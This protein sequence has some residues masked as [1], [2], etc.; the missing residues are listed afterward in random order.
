M[1]P[2]LYEARRTVLTYPFFVWERRFFLRFSLPFTRIRWK[3]SRKTHLFESARRSKM[4]PFSVTIAFS[5]GRAKKIQKHNVWTRIS[6]KRRKKSPFSS[7]NGYMWTGPETL[8]KAIMW[9]TKTRRFSDK[10][11]TALYFTST[12]TGSSEWLS[13]E[14]SSSK[15]RRQIFLSLCCWKGLELC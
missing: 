1:V 9:E 4:V 11:N 7:K 5:S 10:K 14:S 13:S 3:R 12:S 15:L 2:F 6:L 8:V